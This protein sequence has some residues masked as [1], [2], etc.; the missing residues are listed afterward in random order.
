MICP[1]IKDIA[2]PI[3]V[4]IP[5]YIFASGIL[6]QTFSIAINENTIVLNLC[7]FFAYTIKQKNTET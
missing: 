5:Q 3:A 2:V 7:L 1:I 6:M 4:P